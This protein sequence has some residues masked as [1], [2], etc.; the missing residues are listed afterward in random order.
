MV[1]TPE[2]TRLD[3]PAS[4]DSGEQNHLLALLSQFVITNEIPLIYES[5]HVT[6][7][8]FLLD[9]RSYISIPS[10]PHFNL[11][12][13]KPSPPTAGTDVCRANGSLLVPAIEGGLAVKNC[14][15]HGDIYKSLHLDHELFHLVWMPH[16]NP[17]VITFWVC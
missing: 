3:T 12:E 16:C 4:E 9:L 17:I 11:R 14:R 7:Y 15:V 6:L 13:Y 1:L 10:S 2:Y 5:S 8:G